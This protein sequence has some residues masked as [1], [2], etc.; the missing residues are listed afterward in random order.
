MPIIPPAPHDVRQ[1]K[2][3]Q[4]ILAKSQPADGAAERVEKF[5]ET[6]TPLVDLVIAGPFK[7]YT[8][9]N[10]DHAKKLLHLAEY[11]LSPKTLSKLSILELLLIV[12]S[13]FL[14]DMGMSLTLKEREQIIKSDAFA[15]TVREW[16]EIREELERARS[17]LQSVDESE[18]PPI[19]AR[20]FQL[21]EAALCAYLRPRHA[22]ASRYGSLIQMMKSSSTRPDLFELN[23]ASFEA[24]LIDVCVSHNL[25]VGALTESSGPYDERFP[26][27]LALGGERLNSQ[28]CAALLRLIDILDFDRE[29]TPRVL[30]ESLGIS[31]RSL[32][33]ADISLREWQKHMAIHTIE[34][35]AD[36]I[37]ISAECR[38]PVIEKAIRGFCKIIEREIRD[39]LAVTRRNPPDIVNQY[40]L[41]LPI[42]VRPSIK[43]IGYVFRDISLRI[44]QSA[45]MSLLMGERLYSHPA[46]AIREL[47]QNSIDACSARESL[48]SSQYNGTVHVSSS[49]DSSGRVWIEVKDNGI[50]MDEYVVSEYFLRLGDSYYD[51]PEFYRLLRN[52]NSNSFTPIARFGIGIASVFMIGDVLELTTRRFQSPRGDDRPRL[53]RIERMGGL[54]FIAE[55]SGGQIGTVIRVR[56]KPEYLKK[57]EEFAGAILRYLQQAIVRPRVPVQVDLAGEKFTFNSKN[58]MALKESSGQRLAKKRIEA[59]S[60]DLAKWSDNLSGIAVLLFGITDEDFLSYLNNEQ[61]RLKFAMKIGTDT[62][63]VL[64][65]Y[66]GNRLTVNGVKMRIRQP[67]SLLSFGKERIALAYDID[68]VP[69]KDITYNVSREVLSGKGRRKVLRSFHQ[70]IQRGL[71][72]MGVTERLTLG[73]QYLLIRII[74]GR[75]PVL[76]EPEETL[77]RKIASLLP[78]DKWPSAFHDALASKLGMSAALANGLLGRLVLTGIIS[79]PSRLK[80]FK[81]FDEGSQSGEN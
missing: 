59:V 36:E 56:I 41:E 34:I 1:T 79:P 38:H 27:S 29:R 9:H 51:S 11:V 40:I 32:P 25:D 60:L 61:M 52:S 75:H 54:A 66:A 44:N 80:S 37:I 18:R 35:N 57:Y 50:G 69:D 16:P 55:S 8:L 46:V 10:R 39:T 5:I 4:A 3:V 19:E 47:V 67:D 53:V 43:S 45:I 72:E 2:I 17:V 71:R 42:S 28:F 70:A 22:T 62:T 49:T 78:K 64:E 6:A 26:R 31:S 21:Q 7:E 12:Y 77:L 23:G 81:S 14:H 30:F 15:E 48:E 76:D 74:Y 63:S 24:E 65:G 33:G 68:V 20:I 73:T 13:S 58:F